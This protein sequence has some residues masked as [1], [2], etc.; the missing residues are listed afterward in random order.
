MTFQAP[1]P[2]PVV[3]P[4]RSLIAMTQR[5]PPEV[6]TFACVDPVETAADKLSALAWRVH[7]RDRARLDDDPTIIR[8]L[9]DLAAL[10]QHVAS[11]ARF[12]ELVLAAAA[13]DVGRGG[14]A[15]ISADPAAMFAEMLRRLETDPLWASEYEDFVR[16]VSFGGPDELIGFAE[17]L[18]SCASMVDM[19]RES[20]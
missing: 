9:H 14:G 1:L 2:P 8:H 7:A 5:Q 20:R 3:R 18:A 19:V 6:A 12:P 16:Q 11:A 13:A 10:E 15:E 4:I 17:A